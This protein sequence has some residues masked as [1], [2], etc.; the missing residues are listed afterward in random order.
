MA[1][2]VYLVTHTSANGVPLAA[3][4][5]HKHRKYAIFDTGIMQR[6]LQIDYIVQNGRE[7]LPLEVKAGTKGAMQSLYLFMEEKNSIK[8]IRTSLENF[9]KMGNIE[10]YPLYAISNVI[11]N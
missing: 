9:G 8:G 6:S 3:Q 4:L 11:K 10:I 5:N 2:L 7:I 1:G